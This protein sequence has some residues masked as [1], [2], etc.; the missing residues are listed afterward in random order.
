MIK[1]TIDYEIFKKHGHNRELV[2]SNVMKIMR[3]I[4]IKNLL[5]YRPILVNSK[6]EIIDGQHRLEAAKRLGIRVFYEVKKDAEMS[7]IVLLND[8]LKT[9]HREDY[10]NY[11]C[12]EGL[13]HYKKLNSFMN[14]NNV[15]VTTALVVLGR[16]TNGV[17]GNKSFKQGKFIFPSAVEEIES[18]KILEFSQQIIDYI[19]PKL[20]GNHRYI[21][22]ASFRRG[23]YKFLSI[24]AVEQSVFMEK[25]Y[26]RM[27]LI[28]PCSRVSDF[29][30]IFKMI[31][32]FRNRNP[33]TLDEFVQTL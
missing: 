2:E 15:N 26:Y 27:D 30:N 31:Y 1:E 18:V 24:K 21:H 16:K 22:G 14:K 25:I 8:N 28:R 6:M 4:Q 20:E 17:D 33:I 23:L 11:Y 7:D 19:N 3:S 10:L 13:E 9:W 12:T 29:I 5:E 32:N